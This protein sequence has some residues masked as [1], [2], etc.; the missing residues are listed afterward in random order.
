[1]DTEMLLVALKKGYKIKEIPV[2]W[3]DTRKSKVQV[4]QDI[5]DTSKNI[6]RIKI[7]LSFLININIKERNIKNVI[8]KI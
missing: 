8:I 5:I 7:P 1:M 6:L 4:L 2:K 3:Q